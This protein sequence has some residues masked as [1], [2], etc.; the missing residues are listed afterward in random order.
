MNGVAGRSPGIAVLASLL[1]LEILAPC[2]AAAR[3]PRR[4]LFRVDGA[5]HVQVWRATR[6]GPFFYR[7]KLAVDADGAPTAYHPQNTGLDDLRNARGDHGQWVGIVI[8]ASTGRPCVQ[9]PDDPAPGYYVSQTSLENESVSGQC[10]PRRYV[11]ATQIPYF[12]LPHVGMRRGKARLG[13]VAIVVNRANGRVAFAIFADEG[14]RGRIGEG[15]IALVARLGIDPDPRVGGVETRTVDYVVFPDSGDGI[16]L[17]VDEI[18]RRGAELFAGWGGLD[19]LDAVLPCAALACPPPSRPVRSES[20]TRPA[21]P[22]IP[23]IRREC[24]G[25]ATKPSHPRGNRSR[26]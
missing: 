11:D 10:D 9:G 25:E 17:A 20:V 24:R 3:L 13:D 8:D 26:P 12:V 6:G 7:A 22:R 1:L 2:S 18:E 21:A 23:Q 4:R 19:A 14:P 16:P 5:D 15:S